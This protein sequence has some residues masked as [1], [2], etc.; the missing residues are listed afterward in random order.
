[1]AVYIAVH[2][3]PS[4]LLRRPAHSSPP[5][6]KLCLG[7]TN[8][9]AMEQYKWRTVLAYRLSQTALDEFLVTLFGRMN[10]YIRVSRFSADALDSLIVDCTAEE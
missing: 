5:S 9:I 3:Q 6:G 7:A 8:E 2:S 10:F 4:Y 1:V